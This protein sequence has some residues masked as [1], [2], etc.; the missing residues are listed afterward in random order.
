MS[1]NIPNTKIISEQPEIDFYDINDDQLLLV[2]MGD[3]YRSM[4]LR[5][6][7]RAI[8]FFDFYNKTPGDSLYDVIPARPVIQ[9]GVIDCPLHQPDGYDYLVPGFLQFGILPTSTVHFKSPAKLVFSSG[10][11]VGG[12]YHGAPNSIV[13]DITQDESFSVYSSSYI[14][15]ELTEDGNIEYDI[16]PLENKFYYQD[17]QPEDKV[18]GTHWFDT[19]SNWML[20]WN[21]NQWEKKLRIVLGYVEVNDDHYFVMFDAFVPNKGVE[22]NPHKYKNMIMRAYYSPYNMTRLIVNSNHFWQSKELTHAFWHRARI[23]VLYNGNLTDSL[24]DFELPVSFNYGDRVQLYELEENDLG[25]YKLHSSKRYQDNNSDTRCNYCIPLD[26]SQF[27]TLKLDY[28]GDRGLSTSGVRRVFFEINGQQ[29]TTTTIDVSHLE[30][31]HDFIITTWNYQTTF[32]IGSSRF[33]KIR[34]E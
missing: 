20:V 13:K 16:F 3:E 11:V 28:D 6:L 10:I 30:G 4:T 1:S 29:Y 25:G 5:E 27:N 9:H 31:I 22:N 17:N 12:N 7:K 24:D 21:G 26:F 19:H 14:Y 8:G 34:L 23:D 18:E 32:H 15:A 2:D 33:D